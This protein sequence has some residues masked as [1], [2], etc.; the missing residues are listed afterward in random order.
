M[1]TIQKLTKYRDRLRRYHL[2]I[3][4]NDPMVS[5][6]TYAECQL[7]STLD[8]IMAKQVEDKIAKEFPCQ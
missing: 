5:K 7:D 6:P 8:Q 2:A 3:M 1:T 4:R